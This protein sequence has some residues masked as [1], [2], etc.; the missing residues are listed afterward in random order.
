[1]NIFYGGD[2]TQYFFTFSYNDPL[3]DY[4]GSHGFDTMNFMEN[5]GSIVTP[6]LVIVIFKRIIIGFITFVAV[7]L[8]K[9]RAFRTF[10]T[11]IY[12][13]NGFLIPSMIV[14]LL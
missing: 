11:F 1:M 13:L 14:M 3:N 10:G 12:P 8:Y 7:K 4:W 5:M 6:I 2:I 9:I